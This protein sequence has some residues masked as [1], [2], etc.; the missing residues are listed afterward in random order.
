MVRYSSVPE[1]LQKLSIWGLFK[2]EVKPTKTDPNH[3]TKMPISPVDASGLPSNDSSKWFDFETALNALNEMKFNSK[4][5]AMLIQPPYMFIDLDHKENEMNNGTGMVAEFLTAANHSYAETSVSGT[6]LHIIARGEKHTTRSKNSK[7]GLE[8]YT[9]ARFVALTGDS[10]NGVSTINEVNQDYLDKLTAK[11]FPEKT[12]VSNV[13]TVSIGSE[14]PDDAELLDKAFNA[15]NGNDFKELYQGNWEKN[16]SSQSEADQALANYLAFWTNK[17]YSQMDR[18]FRQSNLMREKWDEKHGK[19]T[20]AAI[21]LNTA[22]RDVSDTYSKHSTNDN[23]YNISELLDERTTKDDKPLAEYP[24]PDFTQLTKKRMP[25]FSY[26]DTGNADRFTAVYHNQ[27]IYDDVKKCFYF[28]NGVQWQNDTAK[29]ASKA[30]NNL[31]NELKIE[32]LHLAPGMSEEDGQSIFQ[33]FSKRSRQ[34]SGKVG[35]LEEVKGQV[36]IDPELL[37][38]DKN[39]INTPNGILKIDDNELSI[40]KNT[41]GKLL[42]KITAGSI[43]TDSIHGSRWERFLNEIFLGDVETIQFMKRVIGYSLVGNGKERKMFILYGDD[44]DDENNGNNGKSVMVQAVANVLKDYAWQ[45]NAQMLIETQSQ[46]DN[47][48]AASPDIAALENMRFVRTTELKDRAKLDEAKVK[49]LTSGESINT[50]SLY[51]GEVNFQ[52]THAIFLTTNFKP[53]INGTDAAIWG[54]L[55]YIPFLAKFSEEKH[56]IDTNLLE[57]LDREKDIIMTWIVEG[58]QD[59]LANGLQIPQSIMQNNEHERNKQ[60]VVQ[61]FVDDCIIMTGNDTDRIKPVDLQ[62]LFKGWSK[63]LDI[64]MSA[65][66]FSKLFRKRYE[67]N[68]ITSHGVNFIKGMD[69]VMPVMPQNKVISLPITHDNPV[70]PSH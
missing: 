26:D 52:A 4:G 66:K 54:R 70:V 50:R 7:F 69:R 33:K 28:W 27:F 2:T 32:P 37:D 35:A 56:N 34:H 1:E 12:P 40:V 44:A 41:P 45:S 61:M 17:D 23:A 55:V 62:H 13:S 21:T 11:Y 36:A 10:F 3:L 29:K 20:Y 38:A 48:K 64:K 43:T 39:L 63:D 18:L 5:L 47:S 16:Y 25:Y 22:M 30:L 8:M 57:K 59:Y 49:M 51:K 68:Y 65:D 6:G 24:I 53:V 31:I 58:A 19:Q 60:D 46:F 42:T 9:D 14:L 67:D 15:K